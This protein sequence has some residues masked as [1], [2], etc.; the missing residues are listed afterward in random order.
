LH[1]NVLLNDIF[2]VNN[3]KM[4]AVPLQPIWNYLEIAVACHAA[5]PIL[6]FAF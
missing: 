5:A 1:D 2:A 3:D 4:A 6:L